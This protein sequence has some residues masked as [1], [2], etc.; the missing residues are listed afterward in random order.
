MITYPGATGV[1]RIFVY[2]FIQ[3]LAQNLEERFV[4]NL[5]KNSVECNFAR[6]SNDRRLFPS[7]SPARFV[8]CLL[9]SLLSVMFAV[10][11]SKN[12]VDVVGIIIPIFRKIP[13]SSAFNFRE[14]LDFVEPLKTSSYFKNASRFHPSILVEF[15]AR[16]LRHHHC[17]WRQLRSKT[18]TRY[19]QKS[20]RPQ[21]LVRGASQEPDSREVHNILYKQC[22]RQSPA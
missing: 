6:R 20:I 21:V 7:D 9:V 2:I 15:F 12:V 17:N 19:C 3:F 13:Y 18:A 11:G 14:M 1:V 4:P 10:V 5:G 22:F 8:F 16:H